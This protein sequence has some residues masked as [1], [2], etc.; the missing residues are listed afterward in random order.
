MFS[1]AD[2]DIDGED[3]DGEDIDSAPAKPSRSLAA[4]P[5][6]S[7]PVLKKTSAAPLKKS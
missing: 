1:Q 5:R 4:P 3:I 2:D 6:I 7:A